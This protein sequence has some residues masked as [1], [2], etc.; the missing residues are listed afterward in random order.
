MGLAFAARPAAAAATAAAAVDAAAEESDSG[1]YGESPLE[2]HRR[3]MLGVTIWSAFIL[4]LFCL[5]NCCMR[6]GREDEEGDGG[7]RWE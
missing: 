7:S 4:L 5:A 1:G 2:F 6:G 3:A